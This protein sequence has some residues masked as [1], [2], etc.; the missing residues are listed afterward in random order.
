[1]NSKE[2]M[3]LLPQ[4]LITALIGATSWMFT[5]VQDIKE[6]QGKCDAEVMNLKENIQEQDE[7]LDMLEANFTDLLFILQG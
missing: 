5:S 7:E 1:M 3:K 2:L 4:L 6:H